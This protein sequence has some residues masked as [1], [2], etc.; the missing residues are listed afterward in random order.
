VFFLDFFLYR[1]Y[2]ST[3]GNLVNALTG[4]MRSGQNDT[5]VTRLS[6]PEES[7]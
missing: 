4:K 2:Q 7:L 5:S 6:L 3:F 1:T